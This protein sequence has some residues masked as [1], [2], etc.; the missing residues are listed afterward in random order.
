LKVAYSRAHAATALATP[1]HPASTHVLEREADGDASLEWGSSGC[2][3]L[4]HLRLQ[5]CGRAHMSSS[6]DARVRR[7]VLHCY[8]QAFAS[9]QLTSV[10]PGPWPCSSLSSCSMCASFVT[11][12][13]RRE[14]IFVWGGLHACAGQR[15]LQWSAAAVACL[16]ERFLRGWCRA[17][18]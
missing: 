3:R 13:N 2:L 7:R 8:A 9:C 12:A 1:S 14:N 10:S 4:V 11:A 6:A 16:R 5:K 17:S 18:P 15:C